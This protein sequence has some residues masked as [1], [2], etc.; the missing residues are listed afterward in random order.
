M[1]VT[2]IYTLTKGVLLT[3]RLSVNYPCKTKNQLY[4]HNRVEEIL[5]PYSITRKTAPPHSKAA[6]CPLGSL[7]TAHASMAG[8][9]SLFPQILKYNLVI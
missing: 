8:R 5:S 4:K 9:R 2:T 6:R 3:I 7:T 1:K